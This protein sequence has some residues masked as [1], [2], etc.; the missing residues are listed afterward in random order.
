M[1]GDRKGGDVRRVVKGLERS[2]V[3]PRLGGGVKTVV[4]GGLSLGL[5]E[6][7]VA[8]ES[9][10]PREGTGRDEGEG[11]G[12]RGGGSGAGDGGLWRGKKGGEE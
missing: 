9:G 4:G 3:R 7:G 10:V 6:E 12:G 1:D 2:V 5:T 11:T 8:V